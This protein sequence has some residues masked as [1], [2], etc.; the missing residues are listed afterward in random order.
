MNT[1]LKQAAQRAIEM[2]TASSTF[3]STR[4]ALMTDECRAAAEE[5]R[6]AIQQAES[7]QA[8][9]MKHQVIDAALIVAPTLWVD[10]MCAVSFEAGIRAAEAHHGIT[11]APTASDA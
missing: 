6:T 3:F 10:Y 11:D 8:P 1:E 7:E 2:L 9:M 4:S 5:L